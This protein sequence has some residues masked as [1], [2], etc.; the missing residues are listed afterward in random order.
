MKRKNGRRVLMS[1]FIHLMRGQISTSDVFGGKCPDM[2]FLG[3][4]QM[5]DGEHVR[6]SK[7]V[8]VMLYVRHKGAHR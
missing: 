4:G 7:S 6:P 5:C 1:T 8:M 3:R 2:P